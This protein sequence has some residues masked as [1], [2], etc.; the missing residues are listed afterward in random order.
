[1]ASKLAGTEKLGEFFVIVGGEKAETSIVALLSLYY[2]YSYSQK[3]G[4]YEKIDPNNDNLLYAKINS[5]INPF[6]KEPQ[7][8]VQTNDPSIVSELDALN[9]IK[10]RIRSFRS[11][12]A[13]YSERYP[14]QVNNRKG[15]E[16]ELIRKGYRLSSSE[17][18]KPGV[19]GST[20]GYVIFKKGNKIAVIAETHAPRSDSLFVYTN[21]L[22][23]KGINDVAARKKSE[24]AP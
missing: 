14:N 3:N 13:K 11:Y 10:N 19:Y 5:G 24:T 4:R 21:D 1:M 22:L 7:Y 16:D 8:E 23:L 9:I 17:L 20:T 18:A 6:S 15:I 12:D 2:G